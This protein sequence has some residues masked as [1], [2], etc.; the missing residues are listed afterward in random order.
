MNSDQN[1]PIVLERIFNATVNEVWQAITD[2][3][4]MKEWYFDIKEFKAEVGFA[5]QFTAGDENRQY[6]HLCKVTEVIPQK[7]LS[8]TWKYDYDPGISIVTFELFQEGDKTRLKL[9][10]AGLDNFSKDHPELGKQNFVQGW[11]DIIHTN[12]KKYLEG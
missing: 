11:N 4:K 6:L 8:Y 7:K 12:L 3:D 9:T 5:F 1:Q 2:K 10:H